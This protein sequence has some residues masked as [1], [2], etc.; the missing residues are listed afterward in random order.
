MI[1]VIG[2]IHGMLDPLKIMRDFIYH[3][4][5]IGIPVSKVIFLG[6]YIDC[7]PSSREVVDLVMEIS[8]DFETICLLGNHEEM[9][10]SY[11]N[12]TSRNE[13][14]GEVWIGYNGGAMTILSFYSQSPLFEEGLFPSEQIIRDKLHLDDLFV[15]PD[16]YSAFFQNLQISYLQIVDAGDESSDLLFSHSVPNTR[17]ELG[18]QLQL[19]NWADLQAYV[20]ESDTEMDKTI[21]WNRAMLSAPIEENLILIHGHT[22]TP[23]YRNSYKNVFQKEQAFSPFLIR[24]RKTRKIIQIDIDTGLVY[25]GSLTMLAIDESGMSDKIFPYYVSVEPNLGLRHNLFFLKELE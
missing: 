8:Q 6:D 18:T 7:G 4:R 13:E 3:N 16:R 2:D 11:L 24:D 25:G 14:I 23:M 19:R 9:M 22:P 21:I 20:K 17:N 15:L 5:Q 12:K 1:F 10:L